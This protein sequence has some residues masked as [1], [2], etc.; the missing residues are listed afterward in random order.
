MPFLFDADADADALAGRLAAAE[1]VPPRVLVETVVAPVP[2]PVAVAPVE[3]DVRPWI[4]FLTVW[5]KV[6]VIPS[7]VN[8]GEKER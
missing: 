4:W 8:M 6:P 7:S 3:D 2:E 5:L 1:V